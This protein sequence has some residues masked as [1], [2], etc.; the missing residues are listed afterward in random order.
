[1]T[2]HAVH[3]AAGA[4]AGTTSRWR[5]VAVGTI[6]VSMMVISGTGVL[7]GLNAT[8]S[9]SPAQGVDAGTLTLELSGSSPSAGFSS[10][11]NRMAPGDQVNPYVLLANTGT[12]AGRNLTMKIA[13]TGTPSAPRCSRSAPSPAP[14]P[15]SAP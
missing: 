10:A 4:P 12:L 14:R 9:N 15:P 8:A 2:D 13:A 1:M 11:I 5:L 7:A 6:G 3:T